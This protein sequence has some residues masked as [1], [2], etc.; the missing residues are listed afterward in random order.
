MV[1]KSYNNAFELLTDDESKLAVYRIKSNLMNSI[2]D[3]IK[4]RGWN[5]VDTAK[6]L[7]VSQPRVSSLS[8]GKISKFSVTQLVKMA[9]KLNLKPT[10]KIG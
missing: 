2:L 8:N 3:E 9:V 10:L 7:Q 4:L 6:A 5:Q 1:V